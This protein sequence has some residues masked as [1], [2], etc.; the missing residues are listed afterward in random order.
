MSSKMKIVD[1]SFWTQTACKGER[2]T[3]KTAKTRDMWKRLHQKKCQVCADAQK[4]QG[5]T[6]IGWTETTYN[7]DDR[8][9]FLAQREDQQ[10]QEIINHA[11]HRLLQSA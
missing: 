8:S 9:S 6:N 10:G 5:L 11:I 1:D 4:R 7:G 2:L 3:F